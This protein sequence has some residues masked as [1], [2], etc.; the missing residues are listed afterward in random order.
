M[1]IPER[2]KSSIAGLESMCR[3]VLE[4]IVESKNVSEI[5]DIKMAEIGV[6]TGAGTQV[7]AKYF[8]KVYAVDPWSSDQ[9]EIASEYDMKQVEIIFDGRFIGNVKVIKVKQPSPG[10][11]A[12]YKDG[13]FDM[14]YID[15]IHGYEGVKADI[16]AW[17]PKVKK[18][19]YLCGHD[20][21]R[22]FPGVIHAVDELRGGRHK[23]FPDT[24]WAV[25]IC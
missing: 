14:I 19:G 9:P 24:S 12:R 23:M 10:A 11:A 25:R 2:T 8:D 21:S 7:F 15:A 17:L 5:N 13:S 4:K 1:S 6:W 20:Y 3:W 16:K 22:K 18:G